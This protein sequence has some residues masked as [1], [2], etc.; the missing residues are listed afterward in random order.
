MRGLHVSRPIE[1]LV[2]EAR[3]LASM[4]V[5]ELILIAQELTYYGLDIYKRRSLPQ[6]L[7]TLS[8]L[9][10]IEWIRLHYAYPA[11]FP[12]EI[13][14]AIA[15]LPKVCNYLDM[16]LQHAANRMLKAMK[17]NISREDMETLIARIR[18]ISPGIAIRTTMLVGF[19]GESEEDFQELCDF[20]QRM[21]FERLGVF[22]YSHEEQTGAYKLQDDVPAELKEERAAILMDI[23]E[24]ISAELNQNRLGQT[25]RV[26]IDRKEGGFFVGRTE[27]DSPEVDNEV[28]IEAQTN[29]LSIGDFAEVRIDRS[30]AFDL[31]ASPAKIN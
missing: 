15:R 8:D 27:F 7:E 19:P 13:A 20:V 6:L 21:R 17:R 30:E 11:Q 2:A 12:L 4:G 14:E 10:G 18:E 26:L 5:K 16:P 24:S 9:N 28:L 31:F 29:Y 23:Q 25:Y 3:K 1:E 22:T